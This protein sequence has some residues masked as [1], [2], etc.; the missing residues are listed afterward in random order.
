MKLY[1]KDELDEEIKNLIPLKLEKKRFQ[2]NLTDGQYLLLLDILRESLI[3]RAY[4]NDDESMF[5]SR[6]EIINLYL[7]IKKR[8]NKEIGDNF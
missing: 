7:L 3:D 1:T 6:E 2:F 4:D 5:C 8:H